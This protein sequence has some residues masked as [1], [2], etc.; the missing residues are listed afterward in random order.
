MMAFWNGIPEGLGKSRQF[1]QKLN[2]LKGV[3]SGVNFGIKESNLN[4]PKGIFYFP[5]AL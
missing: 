1:M 3:E 2:S 4:D 5:V